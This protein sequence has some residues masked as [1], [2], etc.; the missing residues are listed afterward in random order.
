[1]VDNFDATAYRLLLVRPDPKPMDPEESREAT[2]YFEKPIHNAKYVHLKLPGA[3]FDETDPV[4][5]EIPLEMIKAADE[6]GDEDVGPATHG[7]S[8]PNKL[9]RAPSD[10]KVPPKGIPGVDAPADPDTPLPLDLDPKTR[11]QPRGNGGVELADGQ[12]GRPAAVF[13]QRINDFDDDPATVERFGQP[14]TSRD[15]D[16]AESRHVR[17]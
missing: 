7:P 14:S 9:P 8:D 16:R 3:I 12:R 4:K 11:W 6:N 13:E 17:R 15:P 2:L 10:P 1:M 5:L